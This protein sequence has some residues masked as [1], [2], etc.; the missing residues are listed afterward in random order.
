[1]GASI[2]EKLEIHE[3]KRYCDDAASGK[4]KKAFSKI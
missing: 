2:C 3:L 4:A 1:M